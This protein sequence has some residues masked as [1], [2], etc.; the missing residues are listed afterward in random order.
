MYGLFNR[1]EIYL[2]KKKQTKKEPFFVCFTTCSI[3]N[4]QYFL[5]FTSIITWSNILSGLKDS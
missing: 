2:N 5:K 3:C 4:I 1:F